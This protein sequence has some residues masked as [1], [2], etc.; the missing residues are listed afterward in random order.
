M[1]SKVGNNAYLL[2]R[3]HFK[4]RSENSVNFSQLV[5]PRLPMLA[6]AACQVSS[7]SVR[8]CH[9]LA[10]ATSSAAV[11]LKLHEIRGY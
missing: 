5:G 10:V 7:C 6:G 3:R 9:L 2:L 8:S 11:R 4:V 1:V